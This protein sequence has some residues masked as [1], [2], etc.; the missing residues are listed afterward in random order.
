MGSEA[1]GRKWQK[2]LFEKIRSQ[3]DVA[4]FFLLNSSVLHVSHFSD[5]GA[6]YSKS[7]TC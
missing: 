7:L 6:W 2:L 3:V 5:F 1:K 4:S